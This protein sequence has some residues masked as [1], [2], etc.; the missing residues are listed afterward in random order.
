MTEDPGYYKVDVD[1]S[2]K[3]YTLT[4]ITTIGIIGAA[5]PWLG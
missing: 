2:A 3:S 5:T 1:L 4:A